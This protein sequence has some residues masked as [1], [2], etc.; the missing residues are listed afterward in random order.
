MQSRYREKAISKA[1]SLGDSRHRENDDPYKVFKASALRKMSP[2]GTGAMCVRLVESLILVPVYCSSIH[3][4]GAHGE[5][6]S[7][8][9]A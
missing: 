3:T 4:E 2:D 9:H 1:S 8:I 5:Q 7:H 6:G